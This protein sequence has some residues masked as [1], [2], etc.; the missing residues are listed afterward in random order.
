MAFVFSNFFTGNAHVWLKSF[1]IRTGE[2]MNFI[3]IQFFLFK[4]RT[5]TIINLLLKVVIFMFSYESITLLGSVIRYLN[6]PFHQY[7][8]KPRISF[9]K[10]NY[11]L[12]QQL[13]VFFYI[14]YW[15]LDYNS[16]FIKFFFQ[17]EKISILIILWINH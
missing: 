1:Q 7:E 4:N 8:N 14:I 17:Q 9:S 12:W 11:F 16:Y 5:L 3:D 6:A 2:V 10:H 15:F 13:R